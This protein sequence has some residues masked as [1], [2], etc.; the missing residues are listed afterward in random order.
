[1]NLKSQISNPKSQ[2][3]VVTFSFRPEV[4]RERQEEVLAEIERWKQ[5]EHASHLKPDAK[6]SELMRLCFAYVKDD[7][8]ANEVATNLAAMPEIESASSP[9][10]R[11]LV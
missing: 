11:R 7:A 5:I 3:R 9:S 10:V 6:M 1:M 8:D 4:S 2:K